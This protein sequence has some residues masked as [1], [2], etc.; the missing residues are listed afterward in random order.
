MDSTTAARWKRREF[1]NEAVDE[2]DRPK[3]LLL[4]G[5]LDGLS[6]ELQ[7]VLS[8][9]AFVGRLAFST[10]E[11]Y[12]AYCAKV[13][14]W[15]AVATQC[16]THP[17][18]LFYTAR[19]GTRATDIA[20][21]VLMGPS[22]ETF[23]ERQPKD[24]PHADLREIID[25]RGASTEHWLNC[26]AQPKPSV[27][28]SLSHGL[29]SG[30]KSPEQQRTLQGA[31]LLPDKRRLLTGMDLVSRPFLPGGIWF[32]LACYSAGTPGRSS[33]E[34]WLQQLRDVDLDA[35]RVLEAGVPHEGAQ[36]FIAALPQAALANPDGP[37]AVIGHVDLAWTSTFSDQG[38]LAHSRFLGVLRT[39]VEGRRVGN[40][41]HTLLRFFSEGIVELTALYKQE[42]QALAAGRKSTVD[43]MI[44]AGLWLL[45]QDLSNY[46]LL[47]D[48]AVRLP[49]AAAK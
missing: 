14:K 24:F 4:L 23:R 11:G 3:Y 45:C 8:T 22:F 27:M 40:A 34:P 12:E 33:Y 13:L 7:Q 25:E 43:P 37:L 42:E 2:S 30:W 35:A 20:Y 5:D 15:E 16:Q 36:P 19:D 41:L 10:K 39:L 44:R 47:G 9:D 21:E 1:R 32:C 49:G 6:L 48:P 31:L 28:L 26:V 29:G 18:V 46:V 38:N 17:R